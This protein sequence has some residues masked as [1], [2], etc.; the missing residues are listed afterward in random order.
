[1]NSQSM[2]ENASNLQQFGQTSGRDEVVFS[3]DHVV[4]WRS[5]SGFY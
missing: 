5:F 1:M 4:K 2:L 3:K